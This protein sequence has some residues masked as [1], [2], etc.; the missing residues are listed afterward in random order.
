MDCWLKVIKDGEV[1]D[2]K[3]ELKYDGVLLA[4]I[5]HKPTGKYSLWVSV[6]MI[7]DESNRKINLIAQTYLYSSLEEAKEG[8][9]LHLQ[10]RILPWCKSVCDYSVLA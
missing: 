9:K 5:F 10:E 8:F 3:W 2:R 1:N 6:P 4:T 7:F